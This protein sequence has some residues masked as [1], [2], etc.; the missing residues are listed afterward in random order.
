MKAKRQL[1]RL[2]PLLLRVKIG[3]IDGAVGTDGDAGLVE[4][5]V[6]IVRKHVIF[7]NN[8]MIKLSRFL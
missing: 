8:S 2:H 6:E 3:L 7:A 5:F 1:L 4:V